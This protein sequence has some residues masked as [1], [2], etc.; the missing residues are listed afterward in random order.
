[1]T[2][3]IKKIIAVL[4]TA[5]MMFT[6]GATALA[7]DSY[8][9][10]ISRPGADTAAHTYTAYKVFSGDKTPSTADP[11]QYV[12]KNID[13]GNGVDSTALL[14]ELKTN[15]AT[16]STFENC[17]TAQDVANKL[18]TFASPET[19]AEIVA[20]HTATAAASVSVAGTDATTADKTATLTVDS[21]GYYLITDRV[22]NG[23]NGAM[24]DFMLKVVDMHTATGVKAKEEMPSVDKK[25]VQG[26]SLVEANVASVGDT[27][28]FRITSK[29]PDLKDKGYNRYWFVVNDKLSKG[30]AY[31]PSSL[32]IK[33]GGTAFTNFEATTTVNSDGTTSLEIVFRDFLDIATSTATIGKDIVIDYNAT[34]TEECD[35]TATGNP[36]TV[37]LTFSNDPTHE[38]DGDKPSSPTDPVGVT[39]EIKTVTYTTGITVIKV[40]ENGNRLT[41]AGFEI[42]LSGTSANTVVI[43]KEVYTKDNDDGTYYKL[44][45]GSYT[46]TAPTEQT[47]DDYESITDK[48]VL[49]IVRTTQTVST[50]KKLTATV[51]DQGYVVFEGLGAGT[52][53]IVEKSAPTGY[54]RDPKTYTVT[55]GNSADP[56]L[57]SPNWEYTVNDGTTTTTSAD[58]VVLRITNV[59]T[60]NLPE[61]GGMGTTFFYIAGSVL[62]LAGV[63]VALAKRK[64]SEG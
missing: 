63:T 41:G 27:V 22:A 53:T 14:N 64:Y 51:D 11:T 45:D 37:T 25:I 43:E 29:V 3:K 38:Y 56:S 15:T 12:L 20:K 23:S 28:P 34:L 42:E 21:Y 4:I 39:P 49:Q 6:I 55:I 8:D 33:I 57:T 61:T 16:K 2:K 10:V 7:A 17:S 31:I 54:N 24:S 52:Y 5:V 36:N 46:L 26:S 40:D 48:Y 59:K 32:S 44:L 18:E 9:I 58:P 35:M 50:D 19:F 60:S 62:V 47:K 30:L 1:M 13:W